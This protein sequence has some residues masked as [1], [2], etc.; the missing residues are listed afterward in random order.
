MSIGA[1]IGF[2]FGIG[3]TIISAFQFDETRTSAG[4]T[5]A[6]G[7]FIGMPITVM[8]GMRSE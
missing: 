2:L 5:I 8:M 4:E 1:G 6:V 3:F 7:V